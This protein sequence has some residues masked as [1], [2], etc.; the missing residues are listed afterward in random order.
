M[1]SGLAEEV[2]SENTVQVDCEHCGNPLYVLDS[3]LRRIER[4]DKSLEKGRHYDGLNGGYFLG[5]YFGVY[6]DFDHCN[7]YTEQ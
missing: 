7:L 4:R 6:C 2:L 1:V 3:I 5:E